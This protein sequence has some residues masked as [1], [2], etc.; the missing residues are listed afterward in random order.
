MNSSLTKSFRT[1]FAKLPREVQQVA[2][3]NYQL[4]HKDHRYPSLQFKP[5]GDYWSVRAGLA[6]RALGRLQ[7]DRIYWFWIGHHTVYEK[8]LKGH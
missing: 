2:V 3:K 4:W 5:V 8:L 1:E 7:G 6:Y